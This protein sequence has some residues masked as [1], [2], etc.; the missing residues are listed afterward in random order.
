MN[1]A[2]KITYLKVIYLE[3]DIGFHE[4]IERILNQPIFEVFSLSDKK[5]NI[6]EII[7]LKPDLLIVDLRR[8]QSPNLGLHQ[9]IIKT[10]RLKHLPILCITEMGYDSTPLGFEGS[11][12]D[13]YVTYPLFDDQIFL[14]RM[15]GLLQRAQTNN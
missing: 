4:L 7:K 6:K 13:D 11:E 9:E 5:A 10:E 2:I 15:H 12:T 14:A 3:D 8:R 1:K